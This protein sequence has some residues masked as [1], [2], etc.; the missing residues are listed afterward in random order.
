MKDRE[1]ERGGEEEREG[2]REKPETERIGE[3]EVARGVT[4]EERF[5]LE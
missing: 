1:R 4:R 3:E 2:K 5:I